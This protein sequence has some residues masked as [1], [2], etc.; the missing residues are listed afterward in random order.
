MLRLHW[1]SLR[2]KEKVKEI[3]ATHRPEPVPEDARR[4]IPGILRRARAELLTKS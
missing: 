1:V 4:E 3:L 2:A